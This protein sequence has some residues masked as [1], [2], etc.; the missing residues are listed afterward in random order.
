MGV[1]SCGVPR[2]IQ[3]PEFLTVCWFFL[4][5]EKFLLTDK[6]LLV[7]FMRFSLHICFYFPFSNMPNPQLFSAYCTACSVLVIYLPNIIVCVLL[8]VIKSHSH[9]AFFFSDVQVMP[10]LAL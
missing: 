7:R 2:L 10:V 6:Y 8:S 3:W 5:D 9:L 4:D 1:P